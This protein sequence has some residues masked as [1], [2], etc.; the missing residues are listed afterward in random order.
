MWVR[1][2][3]Y[4]WLLRLR[5]YMRAH[6]C[7][8]IYQ[9]RTWLVA[10]HGHRWHFSEMLSNFN[11]ISVQVQNEW[12]GSSVHVRWH[13]RRST[14]VTSNLCADLSSPSC[15]WYGVGLGGMTAASAD[16]PSRVYGRCALLTEL[17]LTRN[18]IL[19]ERLDDTLDQRVLQRIRCDYSALCSGSG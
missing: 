19:S 1:N 3:C 5:A 15:Q 6:K 4:G 9:I 7:E 13:D 14:S 2:T 17:T 8:S 18:G 10:E 12:L 16:S 11:V